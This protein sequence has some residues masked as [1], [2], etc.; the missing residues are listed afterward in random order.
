[1]TSRQLLLLSAGLSL[2]V[3]VSLRGQT[4]S[5]QPA[6]S[7]IKIPPVN[8]RTLPATNSL[9][10]AELARQYC[11]ACHAFPAPSLLTKREW[12]HHVLPQMAQWL[13]VEP[14]N[15]EG[16]KDGQLLQEAG[17][18]PSSPILA[19]EDWFAIWDYYV[20]SAPA[21]QPPP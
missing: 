2:A 5:S 16:E 18:F 4:P 10:G 9:R 21:H 11:A 8:T 1:M 20:S 17:V 3:A 14:T 7:S 6:A 13:G 15:Y 19:E 12:A